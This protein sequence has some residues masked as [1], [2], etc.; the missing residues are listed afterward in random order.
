M[1]LKNKKIVLGITGGIA[2]YKVAELAR[3]LVREGALIDT[4]MTESATKFVTPLTFQTLTH[5][6][7]I[8]DM[9]KLLSN[10]DI[11]HVSLAD[12]A[13]VI[14]VAPASANTIAKIAHGICDNILTT[15]I[16]A[17]RA[18]VIIVP[19]MDYYMYDNP[20]T[21]DNVDVLKKRGF[22]IVEPESGLLASGAIGKGRLADINI[23]LATIKAI[24][25]KDEKFKDKKIVITAGGTFEPID[26]VRVIANRS[27]G[28]MGISLAESAFEK[29][30]IVSL[31]CGPTVSISNIYGIKITR[32]ETALEMKEAVEKECYDCD[33]LIMAAAVA[34][35]RPE[36][37]SVQKIKKTGQNITISLVPNPDI[38]A[39]LPKSNYIKVGFAA[40][41]DNLIENAKNKIRNKNL[42]LIIANSIT[43]PESALGSEETKIYIIDKNENIID[44]PKMSKKEAAEKILNRIRDY[45]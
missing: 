43:G 45:I 17:S 3:R 7:V 44:L 30:A 25:G 14:V 16:L 10:M 34:D 12:R 32:V 27:T 15:T 33:I 35:F 13:D 18:P 21:Q 31:I 40:E 4:I 8:T 9:F 2:I 37:T 39:S 6:P 19:A 23:I 5:N 38:L 41:S 28:K 20:A 24:L 22:T 26:P 1:I 36:K 42:D 29:G 11:A